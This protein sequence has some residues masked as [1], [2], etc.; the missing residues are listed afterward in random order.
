MA[1]G[2]KINDHTFWGGPKSKDSVFPKGVQ[3]KDEHSAEGAGEV[4][5][6]EDTTAMIKKQ[7][8]I[9]KAKVKARP[10]KSTFRN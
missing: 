7:Q 8:D 9:G 4:L 2:Q 1:G 5:E 3:T 6:Y 10:L